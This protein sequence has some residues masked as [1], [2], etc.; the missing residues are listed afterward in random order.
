MGEPRSGRKL[1]ITGDTAPCEMTRVAA[2]AAE[3]LVHDGTF[4]T[5]EAERAAETG[6]STARQAAALA[7]E[8]EVRML[9]LVHVSSRYNV[10]AVLEEARGV[11]PNAFAPRDFDLVEVP[12]PER[13]EPKLVEGGAKV[14]SELRAEAEPAPTAE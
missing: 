14:R 1:V 12:F 5:E 3:L 8:A 9:A 4:A 13:G 2:H 11:F 7:A 6:H 10:S